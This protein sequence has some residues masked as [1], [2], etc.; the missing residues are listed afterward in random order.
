[1]INHLNNS[2]VNNTEV[3]IDNNT[4]ELWQRRHIGIHTYVPSIVIDILALYYWILP[5]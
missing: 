5:N 3:Y 4:P 2:L 1:M